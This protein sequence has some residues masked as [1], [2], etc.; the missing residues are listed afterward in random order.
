MNDDRTLRDAAR[1]LGAE[2]ADRV[3]VDRLAAVVVQRLREAPPA[4]SGIWIR[5]GW[6]RIA[7][8]V[9]IL[10]G[11]GWAVRQVLEPNPQQL[12]AGAFF[13]SDDLSDLSAEELRE[14]LTAL[15]DTAF[16]GTVTA[17]DN[18]LTE[19]DAQQLQDVLRSLEG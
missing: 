16:G 5:A 2:A 4:R 11:G 14:L 13:V 15:D 8:V 9:V 17:E 6:L 3:D 19:L 10:A 12:A 1:R 18:D 7:A